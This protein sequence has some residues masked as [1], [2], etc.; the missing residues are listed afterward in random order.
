MA[1]YSL[2]LIN[3]II[4][5]FESSSIFP[6]DDGKTH[7]RKATKPHMKDIAFRDNIKKGAIKLGNNSY[8]FEIGNE[9]AEEKA[10]QYH[11]LEDAKII[12]R[13][14]KGTKKSR[15][16]QGNIKDKKM[17]DYGS[18]LY[19][20]RTQ[21]KSS[22]FG[23]MELIQEYRQN[24]ARNFFG[25]AEKAREYS[26]RVKYHHENK[27]NYI[28]NKHWKYMERI[29]NVSLPFIA[30]IIGAK[31]VASNE[32][33]ES[34]VDGGKSYELIDSPNSVFADLDTGEVLGL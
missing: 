26:E 7:W 33:S 27:R 16:S 13:P 31:L 32:I 30:D 17:R 4:D 1:D 14:N 34:D 19:R 28:E 25:D 8:Y 3:L 6:Y 5:A 2:Q 10:P 20:P 21:S 11:I 23:K 15:G 29:L 9:L 24:Q 22:E 18:Y 12:R